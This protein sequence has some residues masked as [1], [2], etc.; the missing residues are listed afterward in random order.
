MSFRVEQGGLP[1]VVILHRRRARF[2]P[3][4]DVIRSR[5]VSGDR[6]RAAQIARARGGA[7]GGRSL[8][9]ESRAQRHGASR[10]GSQHFD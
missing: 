1:G 3:E 4:R 9:R 7:R 5:R 2:R 8:L 10:S 6:S